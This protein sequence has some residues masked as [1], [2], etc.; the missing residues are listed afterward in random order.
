MTTVLV[1]GASGFVGQQVVE[2]LQAYPV[3][4]IATSCDESHAKACAWF[5]KID[6]KTYDIN[7]MED[8]V[9]DFFDKPDVLIHLAWEGLP[10]YNS[11]MHFE[12]NLF[13][14]Y[15]FIKDMVNAGLSDILVTGTCF[16]YG[17]QEGCLKESQPAKPILSYAFAKHWLQQFLLLLQKSVDFNYRWM[18]LFYLYGHQHPE[19]SILASLDAAVARGEEF[20]EMSPGDQLR[21]YLAVDQAAE[22]IIK[23]ALQQKISGVVNGCSGKPV[24]LNQFVQQYIKRNNYEIKLKTGALPYA[25]YEPKSFWGDTAKLKR[26]L[27]AYDEQWGRL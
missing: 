12:K 2:Q 23:V 16:E 10:Y 27:R 7:T 22:Y 20:F 24:H 19:H 18:R 13:A 14:H 15:R 4:I 17:L 3:D 9:Y 1:T 26:A 6:Y 5:G 25:E 21:D 11:L 8:H